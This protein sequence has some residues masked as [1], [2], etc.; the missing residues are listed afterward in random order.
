MR[1]TRGEV[2]QQNGAC[3]YCVVEEF[4]F[5]LQDNGEL[6]KNYQWKTSSQSI[7]CVFIKI[8]AAENA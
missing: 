6:W 8:N 1:K 4:A 5:Y 3:I 7:E 2:R